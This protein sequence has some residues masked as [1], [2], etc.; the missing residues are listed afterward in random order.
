MAPFVEAS[1]GPPQ[2]GQIPLG[3]ARNL[4]LFIIIVGHL[5]ALRV[6]DRGVVEQ[7]HQ[8]DVPGH[9]P[10][11]PL[12]VFDQLPLFVPPQVASLEDGHRIR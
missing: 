1:I 10:K 7:I 9:P 3:V 4:P 6:I 12:R 11:H 5:S 8:A 2:G